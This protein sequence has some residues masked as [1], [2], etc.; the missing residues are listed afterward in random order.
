MN[1]TPENFKRIP[2]IFK[3]VNLEDLFLQGY[4][5]TEGFLKSDKFRLF[6]E[7]VDKNEEKSVEQP[8]ASTSQ[9]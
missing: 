2:G 7:Q 4:N 5:Q 1:I 3:P 9:I 8:I 6:L